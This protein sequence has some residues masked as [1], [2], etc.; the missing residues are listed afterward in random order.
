MKF[1]TG[2]KRVRGGGGGWSTMSLGG[3]WSRSWVGGDLGGVKGSSKRRGSWGISWNSVSGLSRKEMGTAF[4]SKT[5]RYSKWF[6]PTLVKKKDACGLGLPGSVPLVPLTGGAVLVRLKLSAG[7]PAFL[8][9]G[10]GDVFAFVGWGCLLFDCGA[11]DFGGGGVGGG[12]SG[13]VLRLSMTM[14]GGVHL[15]SR[16]LAVVEG[17]WPSGDLSAPVDL[18]APFAGAGL[19]LCGVCLAFSGAGRALSSASRGG[20][21]LT[22]APYCRGGLRRAPKGRRPPSSSSWL[23]VSG[24]CSLRLGDSMLSEAAKTP[25]GDALWRGGSGMSRR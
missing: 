25:P 17:L 7:G 5:P 10:S 14:L 1:T 11:W 19:V 4:G 20:G 22:M 15:A 24:C 9:F 18:A 13:L 12:G 3:G 21:L 2:W 16:G 23:A 8:A 6:G